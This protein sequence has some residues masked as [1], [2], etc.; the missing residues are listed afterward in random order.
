MSKDFKDW[1]DKFDEFDRE[2]LLENEGLF[3][4]EAFGVWEA[5][6]AQTR[7]ED[8][9]M[10]LEILEKHKTEYYGT[11]G[12]IEGINIDAIDEIKRRF[13]DESEGE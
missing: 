9:D 8:L 13:L 2:G 6:R 12:D 11:C 1:W 5:S 4:N 7:K 3:E 10:V